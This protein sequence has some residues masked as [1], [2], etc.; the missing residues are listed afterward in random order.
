MV[1]SAPEKDIVWMGDSLDVL[2]S[3]PKQFVRILAVICGGC[4]SVKF[5]S[6]SNQ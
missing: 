2:Q 1:M 3:F 4:K 5:R 6:I